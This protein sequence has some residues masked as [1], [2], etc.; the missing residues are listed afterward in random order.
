MQIKMIKTLWGYTEGATGAA[1]LARVKA[2]GFD[3]LEWAVPQMEPQRW[4][5]LLAEHG[6]I[7]CAQIFAFTAEEF[8]AQL[9]DAV[10]YGPTIISAH[11]GRDKMTFDEGKRYFGEVLQA[12]ADHG[13]TV[14]HE[15]HRH[16][17]LFTPWSTAQ[18]L[19]EFE[20]LR[21]CADFSHWCVVCES[22]LKDME[23]WVTLACERTEHVHA[24]VGWEEGP[25]VSDPRAPE[26]RHYLERHEEWWDR[27]IE[28]RKKQFAELTTV[29]PEFGPPGYMPSQPYT[30]QPIVSL[31]D[32]HLW[33]AQRLRKR[34]ER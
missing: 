16:R 25:Q 15:T 1:E 8:I 17:L 19:Q 23:D 31:W 5:D 13:V 33:M 7:Y 29:D 34:W 24:R 22:L 30:Q 21:L 27:I 14:A 12:E 4:K 3:G 28:H 10:Q 18:Y 6:L 11:D 20:Q 2:A 26:Y 9:K 32:V